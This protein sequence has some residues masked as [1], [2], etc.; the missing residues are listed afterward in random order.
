ML[1]RA[2]Y[3][4]V[5]G[6]L[7]VAM[8][9]CGSIEDL[10]KNDDEDDDGSLSSQ[11]PALPLTFTAEQFAG[12]TI[13][14]AA[15]DGY[16]SRTFSSSGSVTGAGYIQS[17]VPEEV[18]AGTWQILSDGRLRTVF[19]GNNSTH[20]DTYTLLD[21]DEVGKFWDV[22]AVASDGTANERLFFN[23]DTGLSQAIEFFNTG[24]NSLNDGNQNPLEGTFISAS[25][26]GITTPFTDKDKV[27]DR[28]YQTANFYI[29]TNAQDR[30]SDEVLRQVGAFSEQALIELMDLFALTAE[31]LKINTRRLTVYCNKLTPNQGGTGHSLGIEITALDAPILDAMMTDSDYKFY[32]ALIKHELTHTIQGNLDGSSNGLNP[33]R[34]HRWFSE[35]LAVF[36]SNNVTGADNTIG[37]DRFLSSHANPISSRNYG[38]IPNDDEFYSYY[39]LGLRYLLTPQV[40]GGAGNTML[41]LKKLLSDMAAGDDFE[42]A[43]TANFKKDGN[44]LTVEEFSTNFRSWVT[45]FLVSREFEGQITGTVDLGLTDI[46]VVK[47]GDPLREAYMTF[48]SVES[49][50]RFTINLDSLRNGVY[51]V[52]FAN[53]ILGF[54]PQSVTIENGQMTP[55][56]FGNIGTWGSIVRG[57]ED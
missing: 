19:Q 40:V 37:I 34:V 31:D 38:D 43:F 46:V 54:G 42:A 20:I 10:I 45:D 23:P 32:K 49:D 41:N 28:A 18:H 3:A 22:R 36:A 1:K 48:G 8:F 47:L 11:E 4:L 21:V 24:G 14:F 15:D 9:G 17:G 12:K 30:S 29:L 51:E 16:T 57:G 7:L 25:A 56:S 53:E 5:A 26:L 13:Y 35:G 33:F 6:V 52:Y 44:P 55:V 27:S 39:G 50:S 2:V